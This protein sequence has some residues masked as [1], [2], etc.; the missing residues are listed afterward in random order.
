MEFSIGNVTFMLPPFHITMMA[1][2]TIFLL[3]RWSKRLETR[4]FTIF[5]Y[6]LISTVITPIFTSHGKEG[7]FRLWIPIGFIVVFPYLFRN[8][9]QHPAK[10]KASLLGLGI[11]K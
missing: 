2:I 7:I 4:R 10:M 8:P 1:I 3:V 9:S 6:F 5:L 11:L